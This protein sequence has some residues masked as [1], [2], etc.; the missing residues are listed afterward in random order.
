MNARIMVPK[1]R[2]F[3]NDGAMIYTGRVAGRA[4]HRTARSSKISNTQALDHLKIQ[5]LMSSHNDAHSAAPQYRFSAE[6][7]PRSGIGH[8]IGGAA[9]DGDAKDGKA[10]R[11][12][13][14]PLRG[15]STRPR[16]RGQ[17]SRQDQ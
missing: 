13:T 12:R 2:S 5:R 9:N 10:K 14:V 6:T 8:A 4:G 17:G 3:D 1:G 15:F 16:F 11:I 7:T